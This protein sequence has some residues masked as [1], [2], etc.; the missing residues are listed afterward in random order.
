MRFQAESHGEPDSRCG[1]QRHRQVSVNMRPASETSAEILFHKICMCSP[2]ALSKR[3][4]LPVS[5]ITAEYIS[6][7]SG[8]RERQA[9]HALRK[10]AVIGIAERFC[11]HCLFPWQVTLVILAWSNLRWGIGILP[12]QRGGYVPRRLSYVGGPVAGASGDAPATPWACL[13]R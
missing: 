8:G 7:G 12:R 2:T 10:A 3:H 1:R 9:Q 5:T 6:C 4:C 11:A 13:F